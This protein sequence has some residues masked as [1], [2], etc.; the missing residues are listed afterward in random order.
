[1]F[2]KGDILIFDAGREFINVS[3][4]RRYKEKYKGFIGVGEVCADGSFFSP[5]KTVK[6]PPETVSKGLLYRE[7]I[8]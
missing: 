6:V 7:R 3:D 8:G 4:G 2:K 5:D 1:M